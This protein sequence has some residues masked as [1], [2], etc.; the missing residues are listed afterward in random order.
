ML[1]KDLES[2]TYEDVVQHGELAPPPYDDGAD[3]YDYNVFVFMPS[4]SPHLLF[5][6]HLVQLD[7]VEVPLL[8]LYNG[9]LLLTEALFDS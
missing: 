1:V 3:D 8:S 2:A 6:E 4:V 5:P 9:G 7:D